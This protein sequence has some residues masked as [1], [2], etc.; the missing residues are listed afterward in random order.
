MQD[1]LTI[2]IPTY[3]RRARLS[4]TLDCLE[5]QTDQR[6]NLMIIDNAS[7]YNVNTILEYRSS[8]FLKRVKLIRNKTNIGFCGNLSNVFL[9]PTTKWLW[10][11]ADDD[12]IM[13]DAVETINNQISNNKEVAVFHFSLYDTSHIVD[14]HLHIESLK[15][16]IEFYNKLLNDPLSHEN[17]K[18]DI[19]FLSGYVYNTE[20]INEYLHYAFDYSYTYVPF[21]N[22]ILK[23]LDDKKDIFSFVNKKLIEYDNPDGDGWSSEKVL[24]GMRVLDD[25]QFNSITEKEKKNLL[26]I[27]IIKYKIALSMLSRENHPNKILKR[28]YK[29]VYQEFLRP[30]QKLYYKSIMFLLKNPNLFKIVNKLRK[31]L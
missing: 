27:I 11:V 13:V 14:S 15:A 5:R 9:W 26:N 6:F 29:D 1:E 18:G 17:T 3:N 28:V 16:Y 30:S 2:I 12:I 7:E 22:I 31:K 4:R 25:I 10:T 23:M 21:L 24:L 8:D 20:K 19:I